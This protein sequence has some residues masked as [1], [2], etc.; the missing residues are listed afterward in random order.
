MKPLGALIVRSKRQ[1]LYYWH[2]TYHHGDITQKYRSFC[3]EMNYTSEF[4]EREK[5]ED[6][7][8]FPANR[9]GELEWRSF[10]LFLRVTPEVLHKKP[11]E[12]PNASA[13]AFS[14]PELPPQMLP[15]N[16]AVDVRV[17][18][19]RSHFAWMAKPIISHLLISCLLN[20]YFI[21]LFY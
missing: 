9:S 20:L 1:K 17:S 19:N 11:L 10:C 6:Q 4:S 15:S 18:P 7:N 14:L 13:P 5:R 8:E 21:Y 16:Q 3:L 2:D 12:F